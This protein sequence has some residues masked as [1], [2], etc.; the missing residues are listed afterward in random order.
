MPAPSHT[1]RP[2]SF[3]RNPNPDPINWAY[4]CHSAL[5]HILQRHH[6]L[7]STLCQPERQVILRQYTHSL[8]VIHQPC[9]RCRK[10]WRAQYLQRRQGLVPSPSL[11]ET[12][13]A[14]RARANQFSHAPVQQGA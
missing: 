6:N 13:R 2:P 7:L 10:L 1:P 4:V 9:P 8:F 5:P 3:P 12:Y 11:L 14:L